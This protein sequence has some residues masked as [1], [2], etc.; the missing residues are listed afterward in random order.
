MNDD[1]VA[2]LRRQLREL[3]ARSAA[4]H[5]SAGVVALSSGVTLPEER[6]IAELR[7]RSPRRGDDRVELATVVADG[8][9]VLRWELGDRAA[10]PGVPPAATSATAPELR[11]RRR[12]VASSTVVETFKLERLEPSQITSFLVGL[13]RR[14][15][16]H[17]GLRR[18][19]AGGFEAMAE[20]PAGGRALLFV[21]GTF[22]A[23][24][25]FLAG[26]R[27]S[28]AGRAFL[29]R[30]AERYDHVFAFDHAT[31][32]VS[33][34]L[35]AL[36]LG[37]RLA[38][39]AGPIDVVAHSRG[40]LVAR[41]WREVFDPR[42]DRGGITV[43]VGSPLA[44][45]SLAAPPR[46]R[47]VLDLMANLATAFAVAGAAFLPATA[48]WTVSKGLVRVLAS[49]GGIGART[50][51]VDALVALVPGLFAQSAVGDNPELL[52]LHD[53]AGRSADSYRVVLA[54]FEPPN[55]PAWR[56]WRWFTDPGERL[57]DLAADHVFTGPNDLVVDTGS[58]LSLG[59]ERIL[60][61]A[62]PDRVLDFGRGPVVHH[63]NYFAQ[64]ETVVALERWLGLGE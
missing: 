48:L 9:G 41:W 17:Q 14:L 45:T 4:A 39:F 30:A 21:H 40:G 5:D 37:E 42:R 16:P 36:D 26:L 27:E 10:I 43:F 47:S 19:A 3:E 64:S 56:F 49:V 28:A 63:C 24:E 46:L 25:T 62:D 54:D 31:L 12:S 20:P 55:E 34:L 33:P 15:T 57:L 1:V 60:D 44:G 51:L 35:N 23:G 58:M 38:G 6:P 32:S 22:S 50:P 7:R 8:A 13:D 2:G 11:R 53:L 52:R 59:S 18:L 61:R 29:G